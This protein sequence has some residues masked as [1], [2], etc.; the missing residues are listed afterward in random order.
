MLAPSSSSKFL[1]YITGWLTVDGWQAAVASGAFLTGTLIQGLIALTVPDY[2]PKSWHGTLLFWAVVFFAVFINTVV[3]GLLP[4]FEGL[5]L[6]LNLIGFFGIMIPLVVLGK[7]SEPADVFTVFMNGGGW[8]TQ[9]LSFFVGL[10]GN[11]FAFIGA[12]G[13]FHVS[14]S[15]HSCFVLN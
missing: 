1:S 15:A 9:G 10:L 7:H 4:K 3:S 12:D 11:V 14:S 6:I 8:P 13:A 5:I 2:S